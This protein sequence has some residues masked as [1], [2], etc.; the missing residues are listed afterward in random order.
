MQF[1][2]IVSL[3]EIVSAKDK[4]KKHDEAEVALKVQEKKIG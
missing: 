1:S 4:D 2:L 3:L